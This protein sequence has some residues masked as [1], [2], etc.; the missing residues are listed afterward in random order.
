MPGDRKLIPVG[1]HLGAKYGGALMG[2][3]HSGDIVAQIHRRCIN[4]SNHPDAPRGPSGLTRPIRSTPGALL[5]DCRYLLLRPRRFCVGRS[6]V[7][8]RS[9]LT[10]SISNQGTDHAPEPVARV[11]ETM[12]GFDHTW[13]L[14]GG[15]AVDAW[16]G[17]QTRDHHDIDIAVFADELDAVAAHFPGWRLIAH[18]QVAPDDSEPWDGRPLEFPAHIHAQLEDGTN[19]NL[20]FCINERL[21]HDWIFSREPRI[22]MDLGRCGQNSGWGLPTLVPR[23]PSSFIRPEICDHRMKK[24]STP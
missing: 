8:I 17:R 10:I 20:E 21:G 11:A 9:T 4:E 2:K 5:P 14:C 7:L 6:A 23:R 16:I 13:F 1:R 18:D 22:T 12:S 19:P 3:G 24:T 15:W